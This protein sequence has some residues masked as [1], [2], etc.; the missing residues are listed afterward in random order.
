VLIFIILQV[1]LFLPSL[2]ADKA[3]YATVNS[4]RTI[5][6]TARDIVYERKYEAAS[7]DP[8]EPNTIIV[9]RLAPLNNVIS[10][11]TQLG[12]LASRIVLREWLTHIFELPN[13]LF[14]VIRITA[15]PK[16]VEVTISK[17]AYPNNTPIDPVCIRTKE[18]TRIIF[19]ED[20]TA[21][22]LGI[23]FVLRDATTI[24]LSKLFIVCDPIRI[25][26]KIIKV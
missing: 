24:E 12:R 10:L 6:K 4:G 17:D 3:G 25:I 9:P 7:A 23:I 16:S 14:R 1:S 11:G 2:I 19:T 13:F 22:I 20:A 8:L 5:E 21:I 15:N 18:T 26:A